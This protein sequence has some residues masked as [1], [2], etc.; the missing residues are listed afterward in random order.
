MLAVRWLA[1]Y[2]ACF[3]IHNAA[4]AAAPATKPAHAINSKSLAAVDAAARALSHEWAAAQSG[5]KTKLRVTSNYFRENH[6]DDVNPEVILMA[7]ERVEKD[8]GPQ[9]YYVKW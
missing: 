8:E 7:L 3:A 6:S 1:A 4:L 5:G 2:I 9:A